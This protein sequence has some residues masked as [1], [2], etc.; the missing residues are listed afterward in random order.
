MTLESPIPILGAFLGFGPGGAWPGGSELVLHPGR[1]LAP[2]G[3][4]DSEAFQNASDLLD[5]NFQCELGAGAGGQGPAR[6]RGVGGVVL[7]STSTPSA[8]HEAHG[9]ETDG[10]GHR[11]RQS[12]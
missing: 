5:L 10:V 11:G 4:M 8:G 1:H 12:G 9:P 3:T 2:A 7:T 6:G